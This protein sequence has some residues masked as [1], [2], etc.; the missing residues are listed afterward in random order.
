MEK[1]RTIR[2][3]EACSK[4]CEKCMNLPEGFEKYPEGENVKY[5]MPMPQGG[6]APIVSFRRGPGGPGGPRG[7]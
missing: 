7:G 2:R 1:E 4:E 5:H 3:D 6:N